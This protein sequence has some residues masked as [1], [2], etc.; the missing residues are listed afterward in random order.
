MFSFF[1]NIAVFLR[2]YLKR[3]NYQF[4]VTLAIVALLCSSK[5]LLVAKYFVLIVQVLNVMAVCTLLILSCTVVVNYQLCFYIES[6]NI[7]RE[8]VYR[9]LIHTV[10][11]PYVMI[12][13]YVGTANQLTRRCPMVT[14][15]KLI[16]SIIR[17]SL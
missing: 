12:I 11:Y 16:T 17:V 7:Y 6:M 4:S 15:K 10:G 13:W 14:M 5:I 1:T 2:K 9:V 8:R 3:D